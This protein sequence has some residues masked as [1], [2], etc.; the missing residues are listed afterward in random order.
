MLALVSVILCSL[1]SLGNSVMQYSYT[2]TETQ[3]I[4]E[5]NK[6]LDNELGLVIAD[7]MHPVCPAA[8]PC[9]SCSTTNNIN[10][11][12]KVKTACNLFD[13]NYVGM[14]GSGD[15]DDQGDY[16]APNQYS[17]GN[18]FQGAASFGIVDLNID[19]GVLWQ[20]NNINNKYYF[21]NKSNFDDPDK[22]LGS[23]G[24][25]CI[26]GN[27]QIISDLDPWSNNVDPLNCSLIISRSKPNGPSFEDSFGLSGMFIFPNPANSQLTIETLN[28]DNIAFQ[29]FD[30]HG[31]I[32][33]LGEVVKGK[34][35]LDTNDLIS[36]FYIF[37]FSNGQIVK[38]QIS[39]D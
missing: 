10:N 5:N 19:W 31:R 15:I 35:I 32:V 7:K 1:N 39:H 37:R 24:Q 30:I 3:T 11:P 36:G 26:N 12:I 14:I 22:I 21:S 6:F 8:L 4:F 34:K 18:R 27:T 17:A 25:Y 9:S 23:S 33:L 16:I 2:S 13:N 38:C 20:D 28:E 29:V